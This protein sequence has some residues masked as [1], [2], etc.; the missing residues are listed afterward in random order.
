[1]ILIPAID[2]KNNECVRLTKGKKDSVRVYNSNPIEQVKF[3]ENEGCERIHIVDLDAA[4]GDLGINRETILNIRQSTNLKIELGG[5]IKNQEDAFFWI[6]NKIDF[7]VIGSLATKDIKQT[8]SIV[9]N[10][11]K[12][13]YI[14]LDHLDDKIMIAGWEQESKYYV[15]DIVKIYDKS[16]IRGYITTDV[17][18]DGTMQGMNF[19]QLNKNL[20]LTDKPIIVGGGLSNY[21]DLTSL[22]NLK[23]SNL[24]GVIAGK[25]FYSGNIEIKKGIQTII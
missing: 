9:K 7:L 21:E 16:N 25:A 2:L 4:F 1:M 15:K 13:I 14:S 5:G 20:S 17:S 22:K 19:D 24:E 12:K 6:K 23:L 10:F 11:N 18:R 3:F 8:L